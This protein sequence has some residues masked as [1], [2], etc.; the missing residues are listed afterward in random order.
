LRE[1]QPEVHHAEFYTVA[2][3]V[4]PLLL[5]T[6]VF[7]LRLVDTQAYARG[8]YVVVKLL[9]LVA[10]GLGETVALRA[11]YAGTDSHS[12]RVIVAV[13]L[14]IS[15]WMVW[16]TPVLVILGDLENRYSRFKPLIALM[17]IALNLAFV[18]ALVYG[19][20]YGI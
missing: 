17:E 1:N 11:L 8:G 18:A 6:L 16:L 10:I 3:T 2:A 19:V 7:Q 15:G 20:M 4:L 5:I 14:A 12:E 13:G 9:V